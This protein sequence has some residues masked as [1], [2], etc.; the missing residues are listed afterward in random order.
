[1]IKYWNVD[2]II[3]QLRACHWAMTDP[4]MTGY[5]TWECKKDIH[6]I[7]FVLEDILEN[8]PT[9]VG[10]TEWLNEQAKEKTWKILS[11]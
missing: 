1:M 4:R 5:V 2:T 8:S 10:E 3:S 9:Y 7:K 6:K 11:Q